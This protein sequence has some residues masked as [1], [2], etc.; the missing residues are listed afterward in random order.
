MHLNQH[1]IVNQLIPNKNLKIKIKK[2]ES[3][4]V[5]IFFLETTKK[6]KIIILF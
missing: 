3:F 5:V 2:N 1:S 6:K 4:P